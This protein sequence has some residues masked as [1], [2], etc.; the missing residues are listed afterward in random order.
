MNQFLKHRERAKKRGGGTKQIADGDL[1]QPPTLPTGPFE[2]TAAP[3]QIPCSG[4]YSAALEI[5][6]W[7]SQP[8]Q[9]PDQRKRIEKYRMS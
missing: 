5:C 6:P 8:C 7:L 3:F 2:T 9:N 4:S 1:G